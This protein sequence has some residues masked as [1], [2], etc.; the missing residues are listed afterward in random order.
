[1]YKQA[2]HC[3]Y[4]LHIYAYDLCLRTDI[5]LI[6]SKPFCY[7]HTTHESAKAAIQVYT[8]MPK[9]YNNNNMAFEW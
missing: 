2:N 7:S 9:I 8:G 3:K 1:M 4:M 5:S 6:L